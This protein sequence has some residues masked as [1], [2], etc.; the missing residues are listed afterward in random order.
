[1]CVFVW[2]V[3]SFRERDKGRREMIVM[4]VQVFEVFMEEKGEEK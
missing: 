1:M 4:L 2:G 3:F